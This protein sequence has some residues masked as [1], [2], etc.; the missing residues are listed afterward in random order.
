MI[1]HKLISGTPDH[2]C[3]QCSQY[4]DGECRAFSVPHSDEERAART[5]EFGMECDSEHLKRLRYKR[6]GVLY[7][8]L[9]GECDN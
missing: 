6:Y 4:Y 3:R 1:P 9:P 8:T 5:S 7:H 2:V